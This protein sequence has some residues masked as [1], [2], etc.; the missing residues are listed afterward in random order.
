MNEI[1]QY[2]KA[3]GE[4]SDAEIAEGAGLPLSK[5]QLYLA[6]LAAKGQ[7]VAYLSTRFQEGKKIERIRC[8]LTGYLPSS[9]PK[10]KSNAPEV[11]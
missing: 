8:R 7:V 2:L 5:T 10:R 9:A 6:E 1:L 4:R 11:N 3:H